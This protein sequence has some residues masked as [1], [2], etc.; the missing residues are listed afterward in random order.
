MADTEVQLPERKHR[1]SVAF[2]EGTTIM[3]A[4][5]AISEAN[6]GTKS[7]AE[8]HSAGNDK[9]VDEVTDLFKG[10]SKK[11]KS[12]KKKD[13]EAAADAEDGAADAAFDPSTMKKKKKSSSKKKAAEAGDFDAKLA[14]AGLAAE[15]EAV[16]EEKPSPEQIAKD[17]EAGTGIWAHAATQPIPYTFLVTR[18]FSLIHSHHPDLLASGSK[19]YKIPPPQCLREG[20]R[21]TIFANIADICKR[22]KR[23]EDHVMQFLFAELGTS[24]SVDGS[25]RLVI[26]G[27]FQQKQIENV[28]RR[29]IVEY[30]TC[31]T[32]RSPDTELNK[33]ENR[34]YFVTCNSCGSR[35]SVTA[36][37]TGFRGQ[38]GRRKRQP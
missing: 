33:G 16:P 22:M 34:L 10:L 24:G 9:E 32:C 6:H 29:Y 38:V 27:R 31:K 30:V 3:D 5:G 7:T 25:R 21:R 15:E 14:E 13:T 23:S 36:I 28:L 37:K 35:R 1:K 2:S 20:N 26:K 18:F 4:N 12:S 17:L 11:K 8:K 19:S